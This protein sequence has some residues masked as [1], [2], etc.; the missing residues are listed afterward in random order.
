MSRDWH[1]WSS[2][3]GLVAGLGLAGPA[4]GAASTE[5][6]E[7]AGCTAVWFEKSPRCVFDPAQPLL[8]WVDHS[9]PHEVSARLDGRPWALEPQERKDIVGA[10]FRVELPPEARRLEVSVEGSEIHLSLPLVST[11]HATAGPS[12]GVRTNGD[13]DEQLG[14]AYMAGDRGEHIRALEILDGVADEAALYPKG[15]ADHATYV[16]LARW[17]QGRF[18]EAAELL[19]EGVVFATKFADR[20]LRR[21]AMP[22]YPAALVELGFLE[23]ASEWATEILRLADEDAALFSCEERGKLLSTLGWVDLSWALQRGEPPL[24]A[25]ARLDDALRLVGPDGTCPVPASVPGI[26]LSLALVDLYEGDPASAFSRLVVVDGSVATLDEQLRL[27]DAELQALLELGAPAELVDQSLVRLALMVKRWPSAEADW[28]LALRRGDLAMRCRDLGAAVDAYEQAERAAMRITALAAVG[29]GRGTAA[30]LHAQSAESLVTALVLHGRPAEALCAAREARARRTQAV[31]GSTRDLTQ[32]TDL[33]EARA[34]YAAARE[35]RDTAKE[36]KKTSTR[37]E[38]AG[39]ELEASRAEERLAEVATL[40]LRE[41]STWRPKCEDLTPRANG[42]LFLGL[43]PARRGWF[44]FV[45]DDRGTSVRW[46]AGGPSHELDDPRL[47][48]ELLEPWRRR[49][50]AAASVRVLASGDAQRV[51]VHLLD[52]GGSRLIERTEVVYGAELPA[53]EPSPTPVRRPVGL[54]V[55][56]PSPT[57]MIPTGEVLTVA[58]GLWLAGWD[59]SSLGLDPG[60]TRADFFYYAGHANHDASLEPGHSLPPY[61]GGTWAWPAH[62]GKREDLTFEIQDILMLPS[63]PRQVALLGCKTGVSDQL[64]GGM[65]LTLAFLVAGAEAVVATPE[66]T[67]DSEAMATGVRLLYGASAN[68]MELAKGLRRA[69]IELLALGEPVGRYRVWVR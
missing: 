14:R 36:L 42:E 50:E 58:I 62:L 3:L 59:L 68:G 18:L 6:V 20:E 2:L 25:R 19:R 11:T 24:L 56:D 63:V 10:S 46:I 41:R 57:L 1:W 4:R 28:R 51:D 29:V 16:G 33:L 47:G 37:P 27:Q 9:D 49:I 21:D 60:L 65:S 69:Q 55:A 40:I 67:L 32:R 17:Q 38:L 43:Y 44:S 53:A 48:L 22:M 31:D 8:L 61:A 12:A 54:L 5:G 30:T 64:G 23:A 66:D 39:L 52:F 7:Y 35:A 15:R 34:Q 26:S 45:Q 13:V